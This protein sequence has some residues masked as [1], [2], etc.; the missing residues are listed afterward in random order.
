[1][2][3]SGV[4]T[5]SI[6]TCYKEI[7]VARIQVYLDAV[8]AVIAAVADAEREG[9]TWPRARCNAIL[10]DCRKRFWGQ[11]GRLDEANQTAWD[12]SFG[13]VT[14]M[15]WETICPGPSST[16][17]DLVGRIQKA[18]GLALMLQGMLSGL[19][20]TNTLHVLED[21][22]FK[23]GTAAKRLRG[24]R[25]TRDLDPTDTMGPFAAWESESTRPVKV[26][27]GQSTS[28]SAM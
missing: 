10:S 1:M 5:A 19:I 14:G 17:T 23:V 27:Q 25:F 16:E 7:D 6:T 26:Y 9:K 21:V 2:K 12:V 11:L 8:V 4:D 3:N 15:L 28:P 22:E 24:A 18:H 20:L 13:Y